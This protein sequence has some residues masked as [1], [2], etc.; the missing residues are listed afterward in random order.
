MKLILNEN[1]F[2]K[3]IKKSIMDSINEATN[4]QI[5]FGSK[6][7]IPLNPTEELCSDINPKVLA[8]VDSGQRS[9]PRNSVGEPQYFGDTKV[10]DAYVKYSNAISQNSALGRKPVSFFVF[11]DKLRNGWKN[12]KLQFFEKN[13]NYLIGTMRGGVFLC[14]YLCPK[15]TSLGMYAFIKEV[16]QYD[17]VVFAVTKDLGDMLERIGC[18]KYNGTVSAKFRGVV[19]DKLIYGTTQETAEK[20]AK[21]LTLM[22]KSD[23]L[24]G[25]LNNILMT[26]PNLKKIYDKNPGIV[27]ELMNEPIIT[28]FLMDNPNIVEYLTKNPNI[29]KNMSDN[30]LKGFL[31]FLKSLDN[32][33]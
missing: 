29:I 28:N 23:E 21:L 16:C 19:H 31:D 14:I 22:G 10:W 20:G 32:N 26:N 15:N 11:L 8:M 9:I 18:P 27:F 24:G 4:H 25:V 33:I 2:A 30:P 7:N 6:G 3:F 13:G 5:S 1:T 17:N 12:G